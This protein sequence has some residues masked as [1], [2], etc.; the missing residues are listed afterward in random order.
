MA[1]DE[2][3]LEIKYYIADLNRIVDLLNGL[4]ASIKKERVH[5]LNLKFD[6]RDRDLTRR[7][8]I[9]RVRKDSDSYITF[10]GPGVNDSDVL[11]RQEIQFA[12]SS[13][14]SAKKLLSTLGFDILMVYEKFRTLYRYDQVEV[15][16]DEMP[17]GDFIEIEGPSVSEI[18]DI[19]SKMGLNWD[20]RIL[21]SYTDLFEELRNRLDLRFRDLVFNEFHGLEITQH[22]LGVRPAD[23]DQ[24]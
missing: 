23:I 3:E 4:G 21:V 1:I 22:D 12:V 5:E 2:R 7:G 11:N 15:S 10:K 16:L 20:K 19:S 8:Q 13:F 6:S 14:E 17:Y 24:D 18:R 9:L